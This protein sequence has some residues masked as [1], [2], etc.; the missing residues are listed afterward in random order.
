MF[1]A[2]TEDDLKSYGGGH[3]VTCGPAALTTPTA[4][5]NTH[6]FVTVVSIG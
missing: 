6:S 2:F 4:S 1:A 5:T 3:K